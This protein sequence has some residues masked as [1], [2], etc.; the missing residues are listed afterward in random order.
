MTQH[1]ERLD[2]VA[3]LSD[4]LLV[5]DQAGTIVD[6]NHV[7]ERMFGYSREELVGR[8]VEDL[9]PVP[10]RAEHAS[11]RQLKTAGDYTRKMGQARPFPAVGRDGRELLV[12]IALT[13]GL[14]ASGRRVTN[15]LVRDV[16]DRERIFAEIGGNREKLRAL[17]AGAFDLL[18]EATFV[19]DNGDGTLQLFR[20][21]GPD[22]GYELGELPRTLAISNWLALMPEEDAARF[23]EVCARA[24]ESGERVETEYRLH[25]R[26]G[27]VA[28]FE[29]HA[30]PVEF[31]EGKP[32]KYL[33]ASRNITARKLAEAE[34]RQANEALRALKEHLED[35][36]VL[37]AQEIERV[38]GFD[39]I[40]G[41]SAVLLQVLRQIGQ[42]AQSN[43]SVLI[44]GET[45]TG[46]ELVAHAIHRSSPRS[47][48]PLVT[49]N[50]AALPP[51]LIESELFGHERGA[52]TGASARRVGRFE[53][54][55]RGTIFLDEIGDLPLDLQAK[56]LRVL[57]SGDC[58]RV[59]SSDT[60]KVD[61][62]VIAATNRDLKEE[63][64][65]GTFRLDLYYR[66]SV[67][68]I[69]LP[70]LRERREDI[71]LLV[72]YLVGKKA[73]K[74]GKSIDRIP[75]DILDELAQYDWPGNVRELENVIERAVLLSSG[76]ALALGDTVRAAF[77]RR[78]AGQGAAGQ[79]AERDSWTLEQAEREHILRIC[80]ACGWKIKGA[81]GAAERLGLNASTLYFRMKKLGISRPGHE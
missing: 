21:L 73:P 22:L 9:V 62:R 37:L 52:F 30:K 10:L 26:T 33:G 55:H 50:C 40:V 53:L 74:L 13:P 77:D 28:W 32:V 6:A 75:R 16:T 81:G 39:E 36:N 19:G 35:E 78:P 18:W 71:P 63:I 27:G 8:P 76:P 41:T 4:A 65:K 45:G 46:K 24:K 56:L 72:S 68:P 58:Q 69:H 14:D 67:F 11:L 47:R 3:A 29:H 57:E 59:G 5:V 1:V 20:D 17:T 70:P 25:T 49:L 61:V 60:F 15:A 42:V 51:T 31:H 66:L 80:N 44:T 54:A 34:L 48:A 12:E 2:P 7:A 23:R 64:E 38:Q 43:S 79:E